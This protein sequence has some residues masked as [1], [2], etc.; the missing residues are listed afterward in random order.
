VLPPA[1]S[2]FRRSAACAGAT[3]RRPPPVFKRPQVGAGIEQTLR[4]ASKPTGAPSP[5]RAAAA[6]AELDPGG[7]RALAELFVDRVDLPLG[8]LQ[9]A[10]PAAISAWRWFSS[11]VRSRASK[12]AAL[13]DLGI[14]PGSQL[15]GALR[16]VLLNRR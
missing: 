5:P 10:A 6:Q 8:G 7:R 13:G 15:V 9:A 4:A 1:A 12:L 16:T 14:Q 2:A 3:S 11:S